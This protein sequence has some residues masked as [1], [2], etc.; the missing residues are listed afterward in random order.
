[1]RGMEAGCDNVTLDILHHLP[2]PA[3]EELMMPVI[4]I[5][6]SLY[7][8]LQK[9]A[10]PFQDTPA[11]VIERLLDAFDG[12]ESHNDL[13]SKLRPT[14]GDPPVNHDYD[15][16]NSEDRVVPSWSG[17]HL[18]NVGEGP[19]RNWDD[20]V[21][22]GFLAAGCGSIF[23]KAL[24]RL[25]LGSK[26]FAYM[27]G[28][29][30][31][32][33]G[34]VV[35]EACPVEE[36]TPV[37][38]DR[39]LLELPLIAEEMGHDLGN[40]EECEHVVGVKWHTTFPR[41][42]AK[43]FIGIFSNRNIVCRLRDQRTLDYLRRVFNVTESTQTQPGSREES[44]EPKESL[45]MNRYTGRMYYDEDGYTQ[46]GAGSAVTDARILPT[47]IAIDWIEGGYAG[48]L[49]ATSEDGARYVG[50]YLYKA[51]PEHGTTELHLLRE[52]D[53]TVVLSGH[54]IEENPGDEGSGQWF[55]R[56]NQ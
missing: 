3:K 39:P 10:V 31:V 30:Y 4:R 20:A 49:I 19:C 6:D 15:E 36:F 21:R 53:G 18:V 33:Y 52:K 37:G 8:R 16:Q 38:Y 48:G 28:L 29:G 45:E 51:S 42:E 50:S 35:R 56:L 55:F 17:F 25:Y 1:M 24:G 23:A 13:K 9:L 7:D 11:S 14:G 5:P 2:L 27:R 44:T 26:V 12:K 41:E 32:G 40:P 47:R 46:H 43:K 34:E 54:W 22:Y